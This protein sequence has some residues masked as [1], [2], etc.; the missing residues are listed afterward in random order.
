MLKLFGMKNIFIFITSLFLICCQSQRYNI[1]KEKKIIIQTDIVTFYFPL[2]RVIQYTIKNNDEDIGELYDIN[3]EYVFHADS[4]SYRINAATLDQYIKLNVALYGI[5]K[6]LHEKEAIVIDNETSK[7][8]KYKMKLHV[9]TIGGEGHFWLDTT[10]SDGRLLLTTTYSSA[11]DHFL[12]EK[13]AI[14][15]E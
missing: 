8:I 6:M 9:A 5:T 10:D 1:D 7:R 3:K 14:K 11:Y 13:K 15:H 4:P 2:N 12:P